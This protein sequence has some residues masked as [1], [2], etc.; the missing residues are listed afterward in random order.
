MKLNFSL[1]IYLFIICSFLS[2]TIVAENQNLTIVAGKVRN[3]K[4]NKVIENVTL[5][6]PGT[7]I[8]TVSNADGYF[9]LKI[10]ENK[11][12]NG[13]KA[14]QLGFKTNLITGDY[15][16]NKNYKLDIYLLPTS[17]VLKEVVVL[18]GD[19]HEI[20]KEALSRIPENYSE[21]D[22]LFSGF[23]RETV[24][25]GNRFISVSEALV[26]VLKKPY[27]FRDIRG[28]KSNIKKGRSLLSQ[29][30]SDTLAV[31][32]A[33][34]PYMPVML[35]I[36]KNGD[37]L[38]KI[39]EMYMYDFK[40]D[41]GAMI[42]DRM[43][44][45]ISFKPVVKLSYPLYSGTL[46][47]DADNLAISR[48]EFRMDMADKDKVTRSIMQKKPAGLRFKPLEVSGVATY[49]IVDGKTYLNYIRSKIRFKCD[50]KRRLFSSTFTTNS[51]I[52]MVDRNENPEKK[53]KFRDNFGKS[54]IFSD[55]VQNYWEEDFWKD[56]N[57]IEPT[58]SLEEAVYKLKK[59]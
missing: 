17:N 23:Y 3:S 14:E 15:L 19:P 24:Q 8:S 51:E 27:T 2:L 5:S 38:F 35:D 16:K 46:Y 40:L 20:V 56:Y 10:P 48:A 6:V 9:T 57:I 18:G 33:G 4:N 45:K 39:E 31:K 22:N 36:V 44:Y 12:N 25:K 37:Q 29:K 58:E 1:R 47:I 21:K 49:K 28:D 54:K 34:G 13:I 30:A 55:V 26:D 41:G 53:L 52:V 50:W 32:L 7:N 42:D 11:L 43:H 59:N